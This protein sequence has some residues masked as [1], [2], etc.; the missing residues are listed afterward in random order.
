MMRSSRGKPAA[1]AARPATRAA[2]WALLGLAFA[3]VALFVLASVRLQTNDDVFVYF[4]YARNFCDG[5][6]FA[7]DPRNLPSEGFTSL[8]YL[9][10]LVPFQCLGA[11]MM[12]AAFLLLFCACA[13]TVLVAAL[14]V[15]RLGRPADGIGA[16]FAVLFALLLGLDPNVR[17]LM[18][19][20]F[21]SLL[22]PLC[23]ALLILALG[24]ALDRSE[25]RAPLAGFAALAF[26]GY[27][28]RPENL[29]LLA[30]L[31]LVLFLLHPKRGRVLWA[32]GLLAA[33]CGLFLLGKQLVFHDIF[34]TGYYRKMGA[35]GAGSSYVRA[36]LAEYS[37]WL[38]LAAVGLG[39]YAV[40]TVVAVRRAGP[41]QRRRVLRESAVVA[42]LIAV[43]VLNLLVVR[44]VTPLVGVYFRYLVT[45]IVAMAFVLALLGARLVMATLSR[46]VPRPVLAA[47]LL[48]GVV[49][50]LRAQ[51]G[52]RD[53]V[54][55]GITRLYADARTQAE[56]HLYLKFGRYLRAHLSDPSAVTLVMGDSGAVPYAAGCRFIDS[57]G[58]TEPG[59]ARLFGEQPDKVRRYLAHL[60]R[61]HP[62]VVVLWYGSPRPDGVLPLGWNAHSPLSPEEWLRVSRELRDGGFG[63]LGTI[64]AYYD[65]H[66]GLDR[67]SPHFDELRRVL[68]E[69]VREN[70]YRLPAGL[71]LRVGS[72]EVRFAPLE[73]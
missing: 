52:D 28:A 66:L 35:A 32:A 25:A 12:F 37:G 67:N 10:A 40:A 69:Y 11:N 46:R 44:Q 53:L 4:T 43:A 1:G 45:A 26:V 22:S 31:G 59:L 17:G 24:R 16:V 6:F 56:G 57:N 38:W 29:L 2:T 58:L 73:Q 62:D 30:P 49:S 39:A 14:A 68:G 65:L 3:Y 60:R 19:W 61:F 8:A 5:R 50:V 54:G 42:A 64:H 63:Y 34:P 72:E 15:P 71:G 70:G 21:E 13:A 55:G 27:L 36:A 7:Y 51:P 23:L 33:G 9:L 48:V 18:G 47:L 41:D 20:P